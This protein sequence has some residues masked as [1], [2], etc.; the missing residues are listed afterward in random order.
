MHMIARNGSLQDFDLLR[1]TYLLNQ[2]AEPNGGLTR[3]DT[4]AVFRHTNKVKL[5]IESTVGTFSVIFQPP[6]ITDK[7]KT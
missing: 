3:Q 4:F 1:S 6:I 7:T 5:D 2:I